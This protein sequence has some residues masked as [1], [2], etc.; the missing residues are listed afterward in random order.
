[1]SMRNGLL[2][3]KDSE[4]KQSHTHQPFRPSFAFPS[5]LK[6]VLSSSSPA[7]VFLIETVTC[8]F[9]L[10]FF[11]GS[12][13]KGGWGFHLAAAG[14]YMYGRREVK[15]RR[16]QSLWRQGGK[17]FEEFRPQG[18]AYLFDDR[19]LSIIKINVSLAKDHYS[20]VLKE[21]CLSFNVLCL[22]MSREA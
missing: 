2:K 21:I 3:F 1:M 11:K 4:P 19:I 20:Q 6:L 10:R 5:F 16:R 7:P 8:S 15:K 13:D 14:A 17:E 12:S 9:Q 18:R 22:Y